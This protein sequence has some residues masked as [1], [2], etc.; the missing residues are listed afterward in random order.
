LE[1]PEREAHEARVTEHV[2]VV[3]EHIDRYFADFGE[4]RPAD[5]VTFAGRVLGRRES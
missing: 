2:R 5:R 4:P 1:H 3:Y